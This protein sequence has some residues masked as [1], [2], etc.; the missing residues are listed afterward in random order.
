M[1]LMNK[2][3]KRIY[4]LH[5]NVRVL[6]KAIT[7]LEEGAGDKVL[8]NQLNNM[9]ANYEEEVK[10]LRSIQDDYYKEGLL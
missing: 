2:V 1:L 8:I 10:L 7:D 4:Q 3:T 5:N 9:I 6:D